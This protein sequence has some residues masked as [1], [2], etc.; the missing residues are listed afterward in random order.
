MKQI[1]IIVLFMMI[2]VVA[3]SKKETHEDHIKAI[4]EYIAKNDLEA[5]R[6]ESGLFYVIEEEGSNKKPHASSFVHVRYTGYLL[7]GTV[8]DS[9]TAGTG[10]RF[11]LQNVISG[12]TE[13]IQKFGEG[14][15]GIL[16]IPPSL[17]YGSQRTGD[18]PANSVLIFDIDLVYVE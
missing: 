9:N 3:C 8:F 7:D 17:G 14:G 13:G 12:W 16:L 2:T 15:S 11:N 18:I 4:E 5:Q 6:T 1:G 10:V